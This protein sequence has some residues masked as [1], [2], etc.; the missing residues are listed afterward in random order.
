MSSPL[1]QPGDQPGPTQQD[2]LGLL[3][4]LLSSDDWDAYSGGDL[5]WALTRAGSVIRDHCRWC[6]YPST[7]V[8]NLLCT[9]APNGTVMLPS[10][11]VTN[12]ASVTTVV[13]GNPTQDQVL[14]T[15]SWN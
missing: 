13:P 9:V 15:T 8:T 6:V 11:Y 5:D 4:P 3:P 7:V 10:M 1:T 12:V 2:P 14:P